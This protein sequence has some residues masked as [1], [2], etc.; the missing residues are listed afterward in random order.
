MM[1][2]VLADVL[3]IAMVTV[4]IWSVLS[5]ALPTLPF[6][7]RIP[8]ERRDEPVIK[9]QRRRVVRCVLASGAAA[10][11]LAIGLRLWTSIPATI[12]IIVTVM[13]LVDM[14]AF[15]AA[16]RAIRKA[17]QDGNWYADTRQAVAV[18]TSLRTD[19]IKVPWLIVGLAAV[20]CALTAGIGILRYDQLPSTLATPHGVNVDVTDR[21]TT[22]VGAAFSPVITQTLLIVSIVI[23]LIAV[24]RARPEL[25]PA[26][27]I[28]SG[29]RYRSYLR[30][31]AI[32]IASSL[33]AANL[34]LLVTALQLWQLVE[35]SLA[36]KIAGFVP[37]VLLGLG[38]IVFL[39]RV[40]V[41]G[42]R[43][44][45]RPGDEDEDEGAGARKPRRARVSRDDDRHWHLYGAVYI[46]R[47]DPAIVVHG[48]IAMQWTLNLGNPFAL[49]FIALLVIA[50]FV[51]LVLQLTGVIELPQKKPTW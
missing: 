45:A 31:S 46:N 15:A 10:I 48:R 51:L 2:H 42:H 16:H 12:G 23:V 39:A 1:W 47:H 18:D 25:D 9:T 34:T 24:L 4:A 8:N 38:W 36:I 26:R 5:L 17:K 32:L 20:V 14:A 21:T 27:P 49:G 3:L 50:G 7:V 44:P 6:A 22:T 13:V 41:A 37:L 28:A 11:L 33:V 29:R 19:P 40:G 43:L 30:G 35:L